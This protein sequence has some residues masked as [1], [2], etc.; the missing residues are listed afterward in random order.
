[1]TP[2]PGDTTVCRAPCRAER[3][4]PARFWK[5]TAGLGVVATLGVAGMQTPW[6]RN[7]W[8]SGMQEPGLRAW[9]AQHPDDALALAYLGVARGRAGDPAEGIRLLER[10]LALDPR[11]A[12]ARLRLAGVLAAAGDADRATQV[13]HD[14]LRFDAHDAE[15]P[16]QLARLCV[17]RRDW[18]G[19]AAAWETVCT[20]APG[21]AEGWFQLARCR[22]AAND[23]IRALPPAL[24]AV[25]LNRR[26][27]PHQTLAADVLRVLRRHAEAD[28]GY[29]RALALDSECAEAVAG[30]A[31]LL[32][33]RDGPTRDTEA[34]MRRAV[35]VVPGDPVLRYALAGVLEDRGK[36]EEAIAEYRHTLRT[37]AA[38]ALPPAA[39]WPQ[40]E[41]WLVRREGPH[42]ALAGALTRLGRTHEAQAHRRA[43]RRLSDYRNQ[44]RRLHARLAYRPHDTSLRNALAQLHLLG[45][46]VASSE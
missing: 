3:P 24:R 23:P 31:R 20:R 35:T 19:A 32:S 5:V 28:A 30:R 42:F 22:L 26:S 18:R 17:A 16:A 39:D 46:R 34:A 21:R 44:V 41:L 12:P 25:D 33:D 36:L 9:L 43:F 2:P 40:R 8:F 38:E 10:A 29:R 37:C 45:D 14:G 27:A 11:L 4:R 13:L 6:Y 7:R 1:M 15:L